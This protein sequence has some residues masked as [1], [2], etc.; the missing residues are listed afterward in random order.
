M[1]YWR[2][3]GVNILKDFN[4][5]LSSISED[6]ATA[7]MEDASSKAAEARNVTAPGGPDYFGNQVG[8]LSYTIAIE[9]L[10]MYHKR[11]WQEDQDQ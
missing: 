6:D 9:L 8:A 4:D 2:G 3:K 11:L 1:V 5:F 10:G 7:I